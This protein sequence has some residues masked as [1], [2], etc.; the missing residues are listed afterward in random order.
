MLVI[1]G[2]ETIVLG[3]AAI[4]HGLASHRVVNPV[5]VTDQP[6][7]TP[8]GSINARYHPGCCATP[9]GHEVTAGYDLLARQAA[10]YRRR[11]GEYDVNTGQLRGLGSG[12][13]G[14][15]RRRIRNPGSLL[16]FS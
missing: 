6:R 8:P 2:L 9:G 15:R 3:V 1:H 16:S 4:G 14:L 12:P 5:Y 10:Y 7:V 13:A 11:A